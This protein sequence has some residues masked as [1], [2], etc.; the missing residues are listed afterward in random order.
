MTLLKKAGRTR[1]ARDSFAA[2]R[3]YGELWLASPIRSKGRMI[4]ISPKNSKFP[5]YSLLSIVLIARLLTILYQ[6][7][8]RADARE[9]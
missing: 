8:F 2:R 9:I 5:S 3:D 4:S 1:Q 7:V 6:S